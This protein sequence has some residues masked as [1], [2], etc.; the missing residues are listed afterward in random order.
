[1]GRSVEAVRQQGQGAVP[2]QDDVLRRGRRG[3]PLEGEQKGSGPEQDPKNFK[4][5]HEAFLLEK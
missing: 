5:S 2:V 3:V 1:M 4:S